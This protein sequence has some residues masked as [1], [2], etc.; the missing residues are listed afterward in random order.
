M[1]YV[2]MLAGAWRTRSGAGSI[3]ELGNSI[4]IDAPSDAS[5]AAS[6]LARSSRASEA[7]QMPEHSKEGS[8]AI[9]IQAVLE[10]T[11]RNHSEKIVNSCVN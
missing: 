7:S 6:S 3:T 2:G 11:L 4:V 5:S 8:L 1:P 9:N 10:N